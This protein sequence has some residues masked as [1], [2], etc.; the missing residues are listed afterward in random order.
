M[1]IFSEHLLRTYYLIVITICQEKIH[2]YTLQCLHHRQGSWALEKSFLHGL[3]S[4][5]V[6]LISG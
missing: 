2:T 3:K 5:K 1:E 6:L 4:S